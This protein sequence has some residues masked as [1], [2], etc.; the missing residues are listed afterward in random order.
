MGPAYLVLF[1]VLL[2][3]RYQWL[4]ESWGPVDRGFHTCEAARVS[5]VLYFIPDV[6]C[7]MHAVH[8][9]H[10]HTQRAFIVHAQPLLQ[11]LQ[12]AKLAPNMCA[13]T[14][15]PLHLTA[16]TTVQQCCT[17]QGWL[18]PLQQ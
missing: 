13:S 18:L 14:A 6:C 10:H 8:S 11:K 3:S 7:G 2:F 15:A 17:Q 4:T 16:F 5:F 12:D 1:L 9:Q